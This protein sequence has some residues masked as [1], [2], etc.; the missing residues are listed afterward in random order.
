[1][2]NTWQGNFPRENLALDG[3]ERTSPVMAF[4][5]NG[6]GK[7]DVTDGISDSRG[8]RRLRAP[9]QPRQYHC[10]FHRQPQRQSKC[11]RGFGYGGPELHVRAAILG[12]TGNC[13]HAGA[14]RP[15]QSQRGCDTDWQFGPG[16]A[17]VLVGN[18]CSD[19]L[20]VQ[21][22]QDGHRERLTDGLD[23]ARNRRVL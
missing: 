11:R 21:A 1:M 3:Y 20:V 19:I 15:C 13:P 17:G 4:P 7:G 18:S 5:P 6:Y 12:W 9:G 14:L 16:W 22:A 2:A 10:E 23:G 8:R